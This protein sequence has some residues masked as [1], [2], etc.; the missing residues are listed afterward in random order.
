MWVVLEERG[1]EEERRVEGVFVLF[2]ERIKLKFGDE[3]SAANAQCV[4]EFS[5]QLYVRSV[6]PSSASANQVQ[7]AGHIR[8][9][10][11]CFEKRSRTRGLWHNQFAVYSLMQP[12]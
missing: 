7:Q 9:H 3:R 12:G 6:T 4:G 10:D 1:R 5:R 8:N 2:G 11:E